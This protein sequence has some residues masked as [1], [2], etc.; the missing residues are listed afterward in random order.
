MVGEGTGFSPHRPLPHFA[1]GTTTG[2][3]QQSFGT[4]P[5]IQKEKKKNPLVPA[6]RSLPRRSFQR[7]EGG[8]GR[9]RGGEGSRR[10]IPRREREEEREE[11]RDCRCRKAEGVAGRFCEESAVGRYCFAS[12]P[13]LS[14]PLPHPQRDRKGEI[15]G[16]TG[17]KRREEGGEEERGKVAALPSF[18]PEN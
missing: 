13:S 12:S 3:G 18:R 11:K 4:L 17:G 6:P 8:G 10:K 15:R 14:S 5:A 9:E 2:H 7:E 16:R 1:D